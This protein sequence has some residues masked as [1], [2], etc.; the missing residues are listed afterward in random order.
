MGDMTDSSFRWSTVDFHTIQCFD[1]LA[2]KS[3]THY[4]ESTNN[5]RRIRNENFLQNFVNS[6]AGRLI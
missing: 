4:I 3:L 6:Q 5:K 2:I 1:N